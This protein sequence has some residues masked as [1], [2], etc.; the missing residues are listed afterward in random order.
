MGI[1]GKNEEQDSRIDAMEQWLQGLTR[2]VQEHQLATAELRLEVL[3]L[4]A[5]LSETLSDQDFD[6]AILKFS[7]LL[8]E[9]RVVAREAAAAAEEG[10]AQ[11]QERHWMPSGVLTL[12]R[13]CPTHS[14][15]RRPHV[16]REPVQSTHLWSPYATLAAERRDIRLRSG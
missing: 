12:P 13:W 1:F 7:D 8:K 14:Q 4:Q 10:W 11:M 16:Q 15:A 9:A 3:K 5:Q 2:V 6:P